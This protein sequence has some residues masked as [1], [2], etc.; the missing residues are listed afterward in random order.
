MV[1]VTSSDM[2]LLY[3][4][5]DVMFDDTMTNEFKSDGASRH[6]RWYRISGTTEVGAEKTICGGPGETWR[7][8]I[9]LNPKAF[10]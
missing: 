6:G 7:A 10:C 2:C 9:L 5:P 4:G 8:E 3:K 1:D